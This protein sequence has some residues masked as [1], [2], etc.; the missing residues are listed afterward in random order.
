[1]VGVGASRGVTAAEVIA[2]VEDGLARA[3]AASADV[4][5]LATVTAKSGE[6]GIV[7]A[8]AHFGVPLLTFTAEALAGTRVPTP[9][10]AP[11]AA[12]GTPS[13]AEAA[14]LLAAAPG[15]ELVVPKRKSARATVAIAR[16]HPAVPSSP[17]RPLKE[18]AQ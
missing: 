13:V 2:L 15:G 9:S 18:P 6:A 3:G 10:A 8:A 4:A 11:L 7:A 16:T 1:V 12:L 5:G 17:V 14:A